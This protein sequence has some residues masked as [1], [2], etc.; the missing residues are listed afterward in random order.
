[1]YNTQHLVRW[2]NAVMLHVTQCNPMQHNATLCNI[3]HPSLWHSILVCGTSRVSTRRNRVQCIPNLWWQ[4]QHICMC[5]HVCGGRGG[6]VYVWR[7][8]QSISS[9][10]TVSVPVLSGLRYQPVSIIWWDGGVPLQT[11]PFSILLPYRKET[12]TCMW[13]SLPASVLI[14]GYL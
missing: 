10:L 11:T 5:V 7:V 1:M 13:L 8:K 2:C 12:Y 9:S 6:G 14:K 4:H 3:Q